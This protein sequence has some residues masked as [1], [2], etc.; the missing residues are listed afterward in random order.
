MKSQELATLAFEKL[1]QQNHVGDALVSEQELQLLDDSNASALVVLAGFR[2]LSEAGRRVFSEQYGGYYT[3]TMIG[4]GGYA[5]HIEGLESVQFWQ[6]APELS[7]L[8]PIDF[9]PVKSV[10]ITRYQRPGYRLDN[11]PRPSPWVVTTTLGGVPKGE[12]IGDMRRSLRKSEW[13][14]NGT[15][16]VEFVPYFRGIAA[17]LIGEEVATEAISTNLANKSIPDIVLDMQVALD[18][19]K[20]VLD[21]LGVVDMQPETPS[22][23]Y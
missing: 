2:H 1:N 21:V 13:E 19:A 15:R 22:L 14:L 20:D 11:K 8:A 6:P 3:N 5:V 9:D 4:S 23:V 10:Q 18:S 12:P 7:R 17:R 16:F